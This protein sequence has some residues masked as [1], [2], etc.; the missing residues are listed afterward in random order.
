MSISLRNISKSFEL[1]S[2]KKLLVLNSISLDVDSGEIIAIM[3]RSG[4]GK[5][6]LLQIIGCLD[7]SDSGTYNIDGVDITD[8]SN[9]KLSEY[10]NK[11]FGFIMQDFALIEDQTVKHNISLPVLFSNKK[12]PE[13]YIPLT[14]MLGINNLLNTKVSLLSG[15]E[16]QRVA[17]ARALINDPDYILADEPTGSL[18]S[19]NSENIINILTSLNKLGKTVIIVTHDDKVSKMC[20]RI[21]NINDGKIL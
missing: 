17:I 1:G 9:S 10:R 4:A 8:C 18:D 7:K 20:N 21:I 6:T 5:S 13:S 11:K 14:D 3:G 19:S 15:G 16:K 12:L 2:K